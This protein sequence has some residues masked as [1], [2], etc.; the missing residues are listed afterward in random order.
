MFTECVL[1]TSDFSRHRDITGDK[2]PHHTYCVTLEKLL[3]VLVIKLQTLT[4]AH[5]LFVALKCCSWDRQTTF[6]FCCCSLLSSG[7]RGRLKAGRRKDMLAVP[8]SFTSAQG[9]V[10]ASRLLQHLPGSII[11]LPQ[12]YQHRG[13]SHPSSAV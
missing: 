9:E 8:V 1:H 6:L 2:S 10:L 12:M 13:G 3:N 7:C 4:P 11:V 5:L